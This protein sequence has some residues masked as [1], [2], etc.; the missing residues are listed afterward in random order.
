MFGS[1]DMALVRL[2]YLAHRPAHSSGNLQHRRSKTAI[3][4]CED[5]QHRPFLLP[6]P[7]FARAHPALAPGE[8]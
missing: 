3:P 2:Q 1:F 4:A 7:N 5:H 8:R 6:R